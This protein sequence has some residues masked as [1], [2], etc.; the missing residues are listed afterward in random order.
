MNSICFNVDEFD[1][2]NYEKK[3][4]HFESNIPFVNGCPC[5]LSKR[6]IERG[7]EIG[8]PHYATTLEILTI[9]NLKGVVRIAEN[10]YT[11]KENS[12][13]VIP[14]NT[15]HSTTFI[16]ETGDSSVFVFKIFGL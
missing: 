4:A 7:T 8:L 1:E 6:R 2:K 11:L 16:S 15:I 10:N 12:E 13:F 14:P 5:R 3:A 9:E